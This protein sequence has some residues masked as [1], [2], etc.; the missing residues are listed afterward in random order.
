[1]STYSTSLQLQLIGN[2]EQTGTW[3]T[4]TNTNWNLVEQAVA[5]VTSITM[6][7]ADYTLTVVNGASDEARNMVLVVGGTN[8]AIRKVIAPLVTKVYV[9]YNNTSGGY[10]IT[11]G[12]ST[13]SAVTVPSGAST[14]VYCDGTNFYG[15]LTGTTGNWSVPGTV[16]AT[17]FSGA[18]TG[19]TGTA[20]SLTVGNAA[21]AVAA[22]TASNAAAATNLSGGNTG[23]IPYQSSAGSTS[24]LPPGTAGQVLATGGAGAAPYWTS[25]SGASGTVTSVSGTGTVSGLTLTG[26]VTTTG[27]LTLGGTLAITSGQVTSALGYT[28]AN[29]ST[30]PTLS[31]TN[32]WSGANTFSSGASFTGGNYVLSQYIN[33]TGSTSIYWTGSQVSIDISSSNKFGISSS[34]AYFNMSDVQKIGGGSFNSYSDRRYKQDITSYG[35]G[36]TDIKQLNPVNY[37][38]TAEFMQSTEPSQNFVGLIAQDV[39]ATSFADSVTLDS[40]GYCV[41]DTNQMMYALINAVKELSAEVDALKAKVGA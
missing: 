9:V 15:G 31:G 7:N 12:G 32:N 27:Y 4:T 6:I 16:T 20:S 21:Y 18:G 41:L 3:G 11:V 19:L 2:G 37:R 40:Q 28:P 17:T 22:V 24:L 39:Q 25:V 29:S 34:T 38:Y 26:N 36:L 10:A 14:L 23:Y 1:M 8:S 13:G 30:T 33:F 35:K 5:G